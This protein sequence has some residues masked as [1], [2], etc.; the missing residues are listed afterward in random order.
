MLENVD[1]ETL[2]QIGIVIGTIL[3]GAAA[4]V[5]GVWKSKRN[6]P[7]ET[8]PVT[9]GDLDQLLAAQVT[10]ED[11]EHLLAQDRTRELHDALNAALAAFEKEA[12]TDRTNLYGRLDAHRAD[13]VLRLQEFETRWM[14]YVRDQKNKHEDHEERL[15]AVEVALGPHH[16]TPR[17]R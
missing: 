4:G 3:A 10:K 1:V 12:K 13:I 17:R 14:E 2:K 5:V 6:A 7:D 16:G 15:R 11:L 9:K 8:S